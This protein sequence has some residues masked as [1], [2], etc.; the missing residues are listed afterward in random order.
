MKNNPP[1]IHDARD[2]RNSSVVK[3]EDEYCAEI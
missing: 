2:A 1:T 3:P